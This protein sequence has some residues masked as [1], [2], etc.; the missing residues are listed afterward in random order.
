MDNKKKDNNNKQQPS[1]GG[2]PNSTQNQLNFSEIRDNLLI[3][4]DVP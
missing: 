4:K 3:M 1:A 2:N